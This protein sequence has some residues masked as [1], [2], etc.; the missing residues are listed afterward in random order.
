MKKNCSG[1]AQNF[2]AIATLEKTADMYTPQYHAK[3]HKKWL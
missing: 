2:A 1:D 3:A